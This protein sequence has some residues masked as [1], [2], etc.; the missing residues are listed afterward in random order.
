[1]SVINDI[2][3][4]ADDELRY[5]TSSE[6]AAVKDYMGSGARR[7]RIAEVLTENRKKIVDESQRL[8]FAKRPEYRQQGG[9]ASSPKQYNQ[10]LRDYDWYLRLI[11]YGIIAGDKGPIESIGLV[12]VREMYNALNVPIPGMVDAMK[13]MKEVSLSLLNTEDA[14]E[15]E[16]FFDYI[17]SAMAA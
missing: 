7:L 13:F 16:P 5:P 14:A 3:E 8:L 6:L 11:T 15:A 10:C 9:N 1:M 17:I 2:I 4:V 12:G